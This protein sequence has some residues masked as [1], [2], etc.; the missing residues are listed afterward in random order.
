MAIDISIDR[1]RQ[2]RNTKF[3][4][5]SRVVNNVYYIYIECDGTLYRIKRYLATPASNI[6]RAFM[7]ESIS[8]SIDVPGLCDHEIF[9]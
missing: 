9:D 5:Q 3:V 4:G 6:S 7:E 1:Y 8:S 2:L